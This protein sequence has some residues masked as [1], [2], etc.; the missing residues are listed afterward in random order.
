M[1]AMKMEIA[2]VAETSGT[3]VAI[4]GTADRRRAGD[5]LLA[6]VRSRMTLDSQHHSLARR[7]C[8]RAS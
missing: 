1:E 8:R 7:V 3:V 4:H 2:V 6:C 5:L